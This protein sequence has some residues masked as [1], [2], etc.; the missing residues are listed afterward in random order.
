MT[1]VVTISKAEA[2]KNIW[3]S[4]TEGN[5]K[6]DPDKIEIRTHTRNVKGKNNQWHEE[7]YSL[8][9]Y[10]WSAC[11]RDLI[12]KYPDAEFDFETFEKDGHVYDCL[13]YPN[14]TASVFCK[15]TIQ[16]ITKKMWLPVMDF[17]NK[18]IANPTSKDINDTKM[19]CLVKT[20]AL[21][22]LGFDLY[23]GSYVHPVPETEPKQ[24]YESNNND[25][26]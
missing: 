16:G 3:E 6:T 9:Y 2:F 1:E 21:F 24:K 25:V 12:A 13:F 19:R 4:F 5:N 23:D 8:P 11:W 20:I 7:S 17:K 26:L 15:V 22:G 18:S 14:D 10:K